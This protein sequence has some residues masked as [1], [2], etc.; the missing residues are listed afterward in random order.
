[1]KCIAHAIYDVTEPRPDDEP[2]GEG[3]TPVYDAGEL[4]GELI[5]PSWVKDRRGYFGFYKR[6]MTDRIV[7]QANMIGRTSN[8]TDYETKMVLVKESMDNIDQ[9]LQALDIAAP[10]ESSTSSSIVDGHVPPAASRGDSKRMVPKG[11]RTRPNKAVP[12]THSIS[13]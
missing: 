9:L 1:M 4:N 5:V 8:R 7:S 11:E 6:Y 12:H 2:D 13:Q 3:E 10:S